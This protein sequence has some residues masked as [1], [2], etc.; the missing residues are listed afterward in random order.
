MTEKYAVLGSPIAHSLSPKI[1]RYVF[2][3]LNLPHQYESFELAADLVEFV[4]KH[5][6]FSGFSVTMPLKDEAYS[7]ATT[8]SLLA[9]Q[10]QS[11][12]T[13]LKVEVGYQGFN[14]DVFGIQ[15]AVGHRPDTVA[16]L[17][18]GATARSALAAFPQARKLVFARNTAA[19]NQ[20]A[21]QFKA[22]VVDLANALSAEVVVSTLPAGVL[23][24]LISPDSKLKTLLDVA[25]TNPEIACQRYV[26]GLEMLIHQAIAQQRIFQHG[27]ESE[28]LDSEAE[29]LEGL[30]KQLIVAK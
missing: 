30:F 7:L 18:S 9:L 24:G 4:G 14:T 3:K 26:S 11:V 5:E 19:A 28:P 23:P 20:L 10:T 13:L 21:L 22:E 15:K 17:G 1:H 29:L 6:D 2:E 8:H 25:Y 12:N 27:S 16:V